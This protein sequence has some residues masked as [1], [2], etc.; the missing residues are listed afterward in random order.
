MAIFFLGQ[1][2]DLLKY[3]RKLTEYEKAYP[4]LA[5]IMIKPLKAFHKKYSKMYD[6]T[7]KSMTRKFGKKPWFRFL[8]I[9]PCKCLRST[10]VVFQNIYQPCCQFSFIATTKIKKCIEET[11]FFQWATDK[12]LKKT[13]LKADPKGDRKR[14]I[15]AKKEARQAK[16]D[17]KK[18]KQQA[19]LDAIAAK[20]QA[21]IDAKLAK[22]EAQ[23]AAREA[24]NDAKLDAIED[25][26]EATTEAA[27]AAEEARQD[28]LD[29]AE[30]ARIEAEESLTPAPPSSPAPPSPPSPASPG[31]PAG[32]P[33][34]P[35]PP[36]VPPAMSPGMANQQAMYGADPSQQYADPYAAQQYADPYAAQQY[37]V[38]PYGGY[39]AQGPQGPQEQYRMYGNDP[40][41]NPQQGA[42]G[43]KKEAYGQD[44]YGV[45]GPGQQPAGY[46]YDQPN[47]ANPQQYPQQQYGGQQYY[48]Q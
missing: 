26:E 13:G 36:G 37:A 29:A 6:K 39:G 42:Y 44:Q 20:K 30:E 1:I 3:Q 2:D 33:P 14:A 19:R 28:A 21:R 34:S 43:P 40:N 22:K 23:A 4:T 38:D 18:A 9:M 31:M 7:M 48:G 25:A 12:V 45:V 5:K 27:E 17:E 24:R 15:E 41:I 47:G 11:G 10:W 35:S 8:V 16:I 32:P 46:G